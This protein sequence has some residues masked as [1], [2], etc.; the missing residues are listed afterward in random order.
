[1][2]QEPID[3][4]AFG[5]SR[6]SLEYERMIAGVLSAAAPELSRRRAA[7][8]DPIVLI[9][10]WARPALAAAAAIATLAV[11]SFWFGAAPAQS[12]AVEPEPLESWVMSEE[13]PSALELIAVI[14][15]GDE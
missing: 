4:S 3:F 9:A 11:G 6:D 15:G 14:E 8:R 2:D 7:A 12:V 10:Q 1:M 13:P 5:I